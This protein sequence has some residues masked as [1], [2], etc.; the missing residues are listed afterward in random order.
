[1]PL[2]QNGPLGPLVETM[3]RAK[4]RECVGEWRN[5]QISCLLPLGV[6]QM[7]RVAMLC[8]LA[9]VQ[10]VARGQKGGGVDKLEHH[11][12]TPAPCL[13]HL[14]PKSDRDGQ[15][16]IIQRSRQAEVQERSFICNF[17]IRPHCC[18][19][20]TDHRPAL[21]PDHHPAAL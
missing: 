18:Q 12:A 3:T 19:Q 2:T 15:C 17:I 4:G 21:I 13:R 1:M 10:N 11:A 6:G 7:A 20:L 5:L 9:R 14:K 8:G 16:W